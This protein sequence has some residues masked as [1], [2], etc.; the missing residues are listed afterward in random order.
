MTVSRLARGGAVVLVVL[1]AGCST[2]PPAQFYTLTPTSAGAGESLVSSPFVGQQLR[3]LMTKETN[4]DLVTLAALAEAGKVK[5]VIDRTYPLGEV[6]EAIAYVEDG[7]A[8]GK[9]VITV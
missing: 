8:R 2:S 7:H 3:V 5:P 9:V 1:L 6:P 4:E